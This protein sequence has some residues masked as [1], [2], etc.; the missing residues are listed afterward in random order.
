MAGSFCSADDSRFLNSNLS[1]M[2]AIMKCEAWSCKFNSIHDEGHIKGFCQ[3][4]DRV[5]IN[6]AQECRGYKWVNDKDDAE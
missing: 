2:E 3:E 4:P 5:E 1:G 6:S